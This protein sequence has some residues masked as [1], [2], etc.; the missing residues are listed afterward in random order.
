MPTVADR[1]HA[2][3]LTYTSPPPRPPISFS[4]Q[5]K[6]KDMGGRNT[7]SA[8]S[9]AGAGGEGVDEL[10]FMFDEELLMKP[11][12]KTT[13]AAAAT[14]VPKCKHDPIFPNLF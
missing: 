11:G 12:A 6:Q 7:P 10:E 2:P 5:Q 1:A 3:H 9:D 14:F 4:N 8:E 13:P